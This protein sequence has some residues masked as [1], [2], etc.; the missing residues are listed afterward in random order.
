MLANFH[1]VLLTCAFFALSARQYL[2]SKKVFLQARVSMHSGE[3][4]PTSST[5]LPLLL[6]Q[7]KSTLHT[8][9][10]ETDAC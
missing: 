8:A 4:E 6:Q 5:I 7:T 9:Q 10:Q 3:L 1:R 2:R